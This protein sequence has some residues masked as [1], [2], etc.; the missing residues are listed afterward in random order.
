MANF[1]Q[2][3]IYIYLN[4]VF[5]VKW[6]TFNTCPLAPSKKKKKSSR[7]AEFPF[8]ESMLIFWHGFLFLWSSFLS[9]CLEQAFSWPAHHFLALPWVSLKKK[10][11]SWIVNMAA[12]VK[13]GTVNSP[14]WIAS[15]TEQCSAWYLVCICERPS[16]C[17]QL[18]NSPPPLCKWVYYGEG[19]G[20]QGGLGKMVSMIHFMCLAAEGIENI[21]LE[22]NQGTKFFSISSLIKLDLNIIL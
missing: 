22:H 13:G 7:Q 11:F 9:I 1:K 2:I 14:A 21:S 10:M 12:V 4:Q 17:R 3:Y 19:G 15:C 20:G 18:P 5:R 8:E 6:V 16:L